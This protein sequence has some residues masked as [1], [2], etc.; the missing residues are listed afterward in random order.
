MD[1]YEIYISENPQPV[2]ASNNRREKVRKNR[3]RKAFEHGRILEQQDLTGL[4]RDQAEAKLKAVGDQQ[5]A[6]MS[7]IGLFVFKSIL[8]WLIGKIIERYLANR[9]KTS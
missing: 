1:F 6:K 4:D 8:S 7:G 9:E 5:V 3:L 2:G